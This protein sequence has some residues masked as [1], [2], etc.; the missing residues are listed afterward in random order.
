MLEG[1]TDMEVPVPTG[2]PPHEPL[3]HCHTASFPREPPI[4]V[5]MVVSP[6]HI[7]EGLAETDVGS[8][9]YVFTVTVT[10]W[11]DVVLHSPS[12]LT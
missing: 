8:E 12:A 4:T 5:R 11:Q 6:S 3:Y 7:V 9:E 10:L 1:K 2:T